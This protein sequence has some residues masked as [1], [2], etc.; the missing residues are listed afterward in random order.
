MLKMSHVS[1]I[2]FDLQ[3]APEIFYGKEQRLKVL[4][5]WITIIFKLRYWILLV[6]TVQS[7]QILISCRKTNLSKFEY[8][9]RSPILR[10]SAVYTIY[11]IF[12]I[13]VL[14]HA[15]CI[16]YSVIIPCM[17]SRFRENQ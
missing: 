16:F 10:V 11:I 14:D 8:A 9:L 4:F 3:I 5:Q 12:Q 15:I 13:T 17:M 7:L 2:L 6:S 1:W